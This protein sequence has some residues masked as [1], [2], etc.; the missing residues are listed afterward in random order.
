MFPALRSEIE[1]IK[2]EVAPAEYTKKEFEKLLKYCMDG[3]HSFFYINR[4]AKPG[5]RIRKN[6]DEIL[7][8]SEFV[9]MGQGGVDN[10]KMDKSKKNNVILK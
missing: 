10:L 9:D 3:Q 8:P 6:L 1:V 4:H 5:E 2:D 7:N